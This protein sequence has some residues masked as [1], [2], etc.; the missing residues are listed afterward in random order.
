M[1]LIQRQIITSLYI[2]FYQLHWYVY[3]NKMQ[4]IK[5][6]QNHEPQLYFEIVPA[7]G[8]QATIGQNFYKLCYNPQNTATG[9][10]PVLY[11]HFMWTC[12]NKSNVR[13]VHIK[14]IKIIGNSCCGVLWLWPMCSNPKRYQNLSNKPNC[15]LFANWGGFYEG[16][17]M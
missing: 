9:I 3:T 10:F 1:G 17:Q 4:I 7:H 16:H 2:Y 15:A 6:S 11:I 14:C 12:Q 13:G 5:A 8:F